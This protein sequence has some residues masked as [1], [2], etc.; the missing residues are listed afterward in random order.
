MI[1]R[2]AIDVIYSMWPE[3]LL[4]CVVL[5]TIRLVYLFTQKKSIVLYKE[6]MGLAFIIYIILLFELV[7]TTDYYAF[8][9]NFIP[10]KEIFRYSAL[11]NAFYKN[12]LGNV[13][14]FL[15]F[16]YFTA[17]FC[18]ISRFYWSLLMAFITSF[19]IES[20]QAGIGR[21]FDIDDIMLNLFGAY[22][23]YLAYKIT[24]KLLT[25]YSTNFKNHLLLNFL[26][27]AII[28]ILVLMI[29]GVYGVI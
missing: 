11:S 19:T 17:Y 25:K 16:G 21:A 20:I 3:L 23:G 4:C 29:L 24:Q 28:L 14:L 9:N 27:G 2:I 18:K 15:P 22:L 6:L 7:T 1:P 10:F 12:V 26:C 5:I 13:V 8:G